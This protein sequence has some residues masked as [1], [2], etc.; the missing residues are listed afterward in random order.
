MGVCKKCGHSPW[1]VKKNDY[2]CIATSLH[3]QRISCRYNIGGYTSVE[4]YLKEPETSS[5][6]SLVRIIVSCREIF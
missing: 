1:P 5:C 6:L 2:R 3:E 4:R